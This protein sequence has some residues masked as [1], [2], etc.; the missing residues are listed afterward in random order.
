MGTRRPL[1][2]R[3]PDDAACSAAAV[4]LV[5]PSPPPV[6]NTTTVFLHELS[7]PINVVAAAFASSSISLSGWSGLLA[8]SLPA[9]NRP[10]AVRTSASTVEVTAELEVADGAM[11]EAI[12][13][14][15]APLK[16]PTEGREIFHLATPP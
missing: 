7:A 2:L 5:L 14:P 4:V 11:F 6:I 16:P 13:V 10:P 9:G 1:T 8:S 12:A 3:N 15:T